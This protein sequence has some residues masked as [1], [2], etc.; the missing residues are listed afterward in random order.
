MTKKKVDVVEDNSRV[1][2]SD[3]QALL[4]IAVVVLLALVAF[5]FKGITGNIISEPT[6]LSIF[7]EGKR[8]TVQ[9]NYP[10][11]KYGRVNNLVDMKTVVGS[12]RTDEYTHCDADRGFVARGNSKCLREIAVFDLSGDI[13][14]SGELV[15]FSVKNTDVTRDYRLQ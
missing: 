2:K 9:V 7:Q 11:G 3:K 4:T 12:K 8:V 13:W 10:A 1:F 15:R 6:S 14:E 5:N